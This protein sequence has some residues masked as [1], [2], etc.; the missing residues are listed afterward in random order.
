MFA[1]ASVK[2]GV[3]PVTEKYVR[4]F[5]DTNKHKHLEAD[6]ESKLL[7]GP[8]CYNERI[9]TGINFCD[10][11]LNIPYHMI[12]IHD[13]HICVKPKDKIIWLIVNKDFAKRMFMAAAREQTSNTGVIQ[14]IP[15][16][17]IDR[18]VA[19]GKELTNYTTMEKKP[20]NTNWIWRI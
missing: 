13:C 5:A 10:N 8:E 20:S 14:F 15:P 16:P 3:Y 12:N 7:Y 2:V 18:K 11:D 1:T 9:Q 17:A 19:L 6:G 4:F